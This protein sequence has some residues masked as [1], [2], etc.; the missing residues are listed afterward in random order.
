MSNYSSLLPVCFFSLG[1]TL[2]APQ[3][4]VV[5]VA[6][7]YVEGQVLETQ[8]VIEF[9][10]ELTAFSI[11]RDGE[12]ID[13]GDRMGGQTTSTRSTTVT[14]EFLTVKDGKLTSVRRTFDTLEGNSVRSMGGE[15]M[16]STSN[17][18]LEGV[19]L[20]LTLD[21]DG[22]VVTNVVDGD[23]PDDETL[24]ESHALALGLDA[25]LPA[26]K[27]EV[28]ESW[29]FDGAVLMQVLGLNLESQLFPPQAPAERGEGGER[30]G[31]RSRGGNQ[32]LAKLLLDAEWDG[33]AVLTEELVDV[34]GLA[35]RVIEFS[36]DGEA[37]IEDP[38][39]RQP[40]GDRGGDA[41]GLVTPATFGGTGTLEISGKLFVSIDAG[42]PVSL[43]A[44]CSATAETETIRSGRGSEVT[45]NSTTE[46]TLTIAIA[47]MEGEAESDE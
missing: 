25:L 1:L 36:A 39:A 40:R 21:E 35:C 23:E 22:E 12:E 30:G 15:E 42:R 33:E 34:E 27:I 2:L 43:E 41:F 18:P 37:E 13:M 3:D 16:V 6:T 19:T 29:D 17:G 14:D 10:S 7:T 31:R 5:S 32:N 44:E 26:G 8:S 47:V 20:E 45:M 9:T 24:L 38:P 11:V 28:D 46:T 4:E